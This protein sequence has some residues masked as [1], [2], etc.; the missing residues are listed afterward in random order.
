METW[1]LLPVTDFEAGS[2]VGSEIMQSISPKSVTV[3][4]FYHTVVH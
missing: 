2:P 1:D 3:R 4:G